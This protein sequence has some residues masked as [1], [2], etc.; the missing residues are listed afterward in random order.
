MILFTEGG[1]PP[2]VDRG[3]RIDAIRAL[4]DMADRLERKEV[5]EM[6]NLFP[7]ANT[8]EEANVVTAPVPVPYLPRP[9]DP[10]GW[11]FFVPKGGETKR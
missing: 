11:D 5:A 8:P 9:S 10:A 1:K 3:N 6:A 4:R 2:F 7:V